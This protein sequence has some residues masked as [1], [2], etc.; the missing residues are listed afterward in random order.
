MTKAEIFELIVKHSREILPEL[1]SHP[2]KMEDRL[3]ELGANS[4]DRAEITML[5]MEALDIKRPRAEFH[6]AANLGHLAEMFH[7]KL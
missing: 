5:T 4:M 3:D 1:E 6:G 7:A 2:F